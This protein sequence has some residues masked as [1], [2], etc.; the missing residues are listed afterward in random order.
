[1]G[2]FVGRQL[3]DSVTHTTSRAAHGK[4]FGRPPEALS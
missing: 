3:R 1:M 4:I 2:T